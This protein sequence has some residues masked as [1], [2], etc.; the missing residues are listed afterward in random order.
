MSASINKIIILGHLGNDP[1]VKYVP[2]GR[3]VC[4]FRVAT[5]ESYMDKKTQKK[6]EQVEWHRITV[7]GQQAENCAKFLKKGRQVL[8]EG[9]NKTR[10]YTDNQGVTRYVT[11]IV[12]LNIKFLGSGKNTSQS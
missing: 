5:D 1:E 7:W 12:A 4:N 10:K 3:A 9:K 2:N 6:V 8:I 11:E